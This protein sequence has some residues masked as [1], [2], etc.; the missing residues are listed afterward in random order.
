[1]PAPTLKPIATEQAARITT[2][3]DMLLGEIDESQFDLVALV[4]ALDYDETRIVDFVTTQIVYD[5]YPG[6]L[7]GAK[8]TLVSRAGNSLD[9]SILLAH[10]LREAGLDARI[11]HGTAPGSVI[12][13]ASHDQRAIRPPVF[14]TPDVLQRVGT[15]LNPPGTAGRT[16]TD[17]EKNQARNAVITRPATLAKLTSDI[18]QAV[19]P[20]ATSAGS[21]SRP[22]FWVD[23]RLGPSDPWQAAHPAIGA[24]ASPGNIEVAGYIADSV[25]PELQ[26]RIRIQAFIERSLRGKLESQAV[27]RRYEYPAANLSGVTFKYSVI[28]SA[29]LASEHPVSDQGE[30]MLAASNLFFPVFDFGAPGLDLAFD[31]TGNV[32]AADDALNSMAALYQTLGKGFLSAADALNGN[33]SPAEGG[34]PS[35]HVTRHWVEIT[36]LRPGLE[37]RT[38]TR[39]I[40]RWQGDESVLKQS[41]ART[42]YFRVEAGAVSPAE[43][44]HRSL[45]TQREL[46]R[47]LSSD[48][49]LAL[50]DGMLAQFSLDAEIFLLTSDMAA[51][52]NN[53]ERSYRAEPAI[54]ARYLPYGRI[55]ASREGFDIINAPRVAVSPAAGTQDKRATLYNGIV[56]TWLEHELFAGEQWSRSAYGRLQQRLNAGGALTVLAESQRLPHAVPA[57]TGKLIVKDLEDHQRVVLVGPAEQCDAWW[58]V[59]PQSGAAVGVLANGWGGVV[60]EYLK[61]LAA[62]HGKVKIASLA[63]GCGLTVPFITASAAVNAAGLFQLDEALGFAGLDL[64]SHIPDPSLQGLCTLTVAGAS[65]ASAS[66]AAG[67]GLSTSMLVRICVMSA[68]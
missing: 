10:L 67:S 13:P 27:T 64:C 57:P 49:P 29:F 21:K 62:V 5:D 59:D 58:R 30:Q 65:M 36:L 63:A 60:P 51:A 47:S 9:Q 34:S 44:L 15:S 26:Q 38:F 18:Y 23:Y 41:L 6:V 43:I 54:I 68:L 35:V 31:T 11:V 66:G 25:D 12:P 22:Y 53:A 48:T 1:M 39:D 32:L 14:N 33:V 56:D 52:E 24:K 40:A 61:N 7:R 2:A 45:K 19:Q 17:G 28:P 4:D 8:G 46:V 42:A 55:D 20:I 3:L 37:P 16:L 50:E